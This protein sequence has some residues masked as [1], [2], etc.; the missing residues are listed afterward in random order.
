MAALA[1]ATTING[2][3][4]VVPAFNASN[5]IDACLASLRAQRTD[6]PIEVVVVDDGSSDD[7][8]A[9][10]RQWQARFAQLHMSLRVIQ[11]A[12][13]G[14]ARARNAG[15]DCLLYTSPSPRDRG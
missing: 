9:K 7:T 14:A 2:V 15:I 3:T 8:S 5:T 6:L 11:Q 13:G 1:A 4:C 10:A 12:N